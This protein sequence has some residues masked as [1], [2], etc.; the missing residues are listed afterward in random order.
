MSSAL[1]Y[2]IIVSLGNQ[3]AVEKALA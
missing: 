1:R 2:K 3:F